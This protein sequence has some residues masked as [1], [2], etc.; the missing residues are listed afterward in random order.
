MDCDLITEIHFELVDGFIHIFGRLL[1]LNGN[2]VIDFLNADP[3]S[4]S[5]NCDLQALCILYALLMKGVGLAD[6]LI[7]EYLVTLARCSEA[8]FQKIFSVV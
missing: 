5:Q 3:L 6:D 7:V 8:F 1:I 2:R 4:F